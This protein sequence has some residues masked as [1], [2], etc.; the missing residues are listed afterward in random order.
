MTSTINEIKERVDKFAIVLT[1]IPRGVSLYAWRKGIPKT[2]EKTVIESEHGA[3]LS[4][5]LQQGEKRKEVHIFVCSATHDTLDR[6]LEGEDPRLAGLDMEPYIDSNDP[7]KIKLGRQLLR[8]HCYELDINDKPV[9]GKILLNK[10]KWEAYH[11]DCWNWADS[12]N[13]VYWDSFVLC[14]EMAEHFSTNPLARDRGKNFTSWENQYLHFVAAFHQNQEFF[15]SLTESSVVIRHR[16]DLILKPKYSAWR[17]AEL[18]HSNYYSNPHDPESWNKHHMGFSKSPKVLVPQT[19]IFRGQVGAPD[20]WSAFD[21]PGACLFGHEYV[22][23]LKNDINRWY[24]PLKITDDENI[25]FHMPEHSLPQF[26]LEHN[27]T[28]IQTIDRILQMMSLKDPPILDQ[29]RYHWYNW[30][31]EMVKEVREKCV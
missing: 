27:Y 16:Y 13:F 15:E 19:S 23:Y 28:I 14:K 1:G 31:K 2:Y 29:Y 26:C 21:G 22:N 30:T 3:H 7:E 17:F 18:L 24:L 4:H 25:Y 6:Y 9:G 20:Y 8:E 11:R 12:V 10:E 5:W